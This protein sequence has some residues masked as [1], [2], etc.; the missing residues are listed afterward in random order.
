MSSQVRLRLLPS[1]RCMF[2]EPVQLKVAG[3]RPRQVV[4]IRATATDERRVVFNSAA[5]YRADESGEVDLDRDPSLGGSYVGV[6]PMGLLWS[7]K[8]DDLHKYFFKSKAQDPHVVKFSVHEEEEGRM[9]AEA[10][11]ERCLIGE[12]VSRLPVK[13]GNFQGILFVPPGEGPFPAVLDI[14][15]FKSE[16]RAS[17]LANKGFVVL[18]LAVYTDKPD[19]YK[20]MRLEYFE[21]A[22][23]FLKQ[24]PKVG[25][26]GVGV[27]SRSKGGDVALSVGTFLPG[28]AATVWI[29]GCCANTA[30]PLYYKNSQILPAL[31]FDP[32]KL[33]ASE[34][35]AY[36]GMCAMH[37]PLA[38]ENKASLVP[39]ERAKGHFLFVASEDDLNWDSKAY[40][41]QMIERLMHHG[42]KNFESVCYPGAGHYLEP[43]FGPFCSSSFH[44]IVNKPVLWGGVPGPFASKVMSSQVRLR[45]LPSSRCMFDEP[46]QLKVAGLRPRQVVT[47]RA[48]AT[49]ERRVVFNSAASYRADESGEVDLDRDPSLGGS[50]VGVEPMGLLWSLKADDLH[51]Y[52]FKNKAQ[53]PHV[54]K[55]SVHEEEEGRMLAE[56]TNERCLI[57]EGVSRLPVNEGNFQGILFVPPGEGPF[58]A[59]LDLS[60]FPSEKRASLLANKGFVVLAM[61]VYTDKTDTSKEMHLDVFE[62][63]VNFLKRQPKVGS[64]GVGVI[65]RSKGGDIALSMAAFVSG[66]EATVWINGS[67]TNVGVPLCYK[68]RPILSPIQFDP[69]RVIV[70]ESGAWNIRHVMTNPLAEENKNSLIPIERAPGCFL[71]VAAE[72]DLNWDSKGFM[73]EMVERLKHH[74]KKNFESVCYPK[75]G[76]MM[77]PPYSPHC[78]SAVHGLVKNAVLW[79]GDPSIHA[80][81]EVHMWKKIQD[82]LRTHLSTGEMLSKAKI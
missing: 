73:E 56:A 20:T 15:T 35:G 21:E 80:V 58:P 27:I 55:F 54:V 69:S 67:S 82:F 74:G 79:G 81:A 12:G 64:K 76:H 78:P 61:A 17:L 66:I 39:I 52:F 11:N 29:N 44:R 75:A 70:T 23:E 33:I 31:M 26:K 77:E 60:T 9:L 34:S 22:V 71:F 62:E 51:K 32:N 63:A 10:T 41:E 30:I 45:L 53:D 5:S 25:N 2:D 7:L 59:V 16:K 37:N 40:M 4:T 68:Q 18:C 65:A 36:I 13:E 14:S 42:K 19:A 6:E 49:D 1:S 46:V 57:G 72:D 3:L 28:I 8:A 43:P 48:T 50:Y 47:I 38:E 24:Q